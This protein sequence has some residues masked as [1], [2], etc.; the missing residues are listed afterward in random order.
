MLMK[1]E[2]NASIDLLALRPLERK[3]IWEQPGRGIQFPI[4]KEIIVLVLQR[5]QNTM[6][7]DFL[8]LFFSSKLFRKC[9]RLFLQLMVLFFS[10]YICV[11]QTTKEDIFLSLSPHFSLR[12]SF[13][14]MCVVHPFICGFR[15]QHI[16]IMFVHV[17]VWHAHC[18]LIICPCVLP[19][20]RYWSDHIKYG[21]GCLWRQ[22]DWVSREA[23]GWRGEDRC[24][25]ACEY[26]WKC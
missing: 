22:P 20:N 1:W 25:D 12:V 17:C 2:E 26:W 4:K 13:P 16:D 14:A 23:Y 10:V 21:E 18:L 19:A 3:K 15:K 6:F 24:G 11:N 7:G 8:Q 5:L 9:Y